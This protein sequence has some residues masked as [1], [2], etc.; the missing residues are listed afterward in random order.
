MLIILQDFESVLS[1]AIANDGKAVC[2]FYFALIARIFFSIHRFG[3]VVGLRPNV[4]IKDVKQTCQKML[5]QLAEPK[6][7][8][9]GKTKVTSDSCES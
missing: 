9:I 6:G 1:V 2:S 3:I 5:R 8:I 4:P 7:W